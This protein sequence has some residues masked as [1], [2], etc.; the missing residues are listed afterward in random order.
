MTEKKS[1]LL[2]SL[3][4]LTCNP[5][6]LAPLVLA[7]GSIGFGGG[8]CAASAFGWSDSARVA[9]VS[10]V[11]PTS[12]TTPTATLVPPL[13]TPTVPVAVPRGPIVA[14]RFDPPVAATP[15]PSQPVIIVIHEH[16]E[17]ALPTRAGM[18]QASTPS[19][20]Y[21]VP[22]PVDCWPGPA[23]RCR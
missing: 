2:T 13:P 12:T 18:P 3:Q 11:V 6:T 19:P 4:S 14:P 1:S 20:T 16:G 9:V 8:A 15:A 5:K 23:R 7:L 21:T 22:P 17:G 10:P